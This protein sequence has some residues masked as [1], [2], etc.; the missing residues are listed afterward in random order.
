[1]LGENV[2]VVVLKN[3]KAWM[4]FFMLRK[5][6]KEGELPKWMNPKPR[7]RKRNIFC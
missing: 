4:S 2:K 7:V 1:V 6:K 5:K 3:M